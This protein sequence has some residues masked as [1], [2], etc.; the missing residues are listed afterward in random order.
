MNQ[1]DR[2]K[3]YED[4]KRKC[5]NGTYGK[6]VKGSSY[7]MKNSNSRLDNIL[8]KK[9]YDKTYVEVVNDDV[10]A[11]ANRLHTDGEKNILVLNLASDYRAG[12]GVERGAMAQEEELFRRS[13]YFMNLDNTFYPLEPASVVY[14]PNVLIVKDRHYT[15][16]GT[17]FTVS[18]LAVA[19][20]RNPKLT[21]KGEYYDSD[22]KIMFDSIH[23]IFKIAY[24]MNHETLVLGALGCGAFHNPPTEV[25]KIYNIFLE[26]YDGCFK[27]VVFAVYSRRDDNFTYFSKYIKG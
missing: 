23:N 9:K 22:Y 24:M 3:V 21:K 6:L 1:L 2:I 25:I 7:L 5:L 4:T 17:P 18:M 27:N 26:K 8:F 20:I 16:L 14:T 13:N 12:G 11:V 19:A 10:L 15:D